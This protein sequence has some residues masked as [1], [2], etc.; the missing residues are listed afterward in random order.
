MRRTRPDKGITVLYEEDQTRWITVLSEED[1]P[2]GITEPMCV[3]L[4]LHL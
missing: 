1:Q 4:N 2:R 3:Y